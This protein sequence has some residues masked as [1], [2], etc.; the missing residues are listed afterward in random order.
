VPIRALENISRGT[1]INFVFASLRGGAL[2]DIHPI[3]KSPFV[4]YLL[5]SFFKST[6][7]SA[8]STPLGLTRIVNRDMSN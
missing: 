1:P 2:K 3:P 5:V 8:I 4:V 6:S 7:L